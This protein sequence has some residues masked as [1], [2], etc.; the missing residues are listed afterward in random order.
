MIL[1][2]VKIIILFLLI[3]WH[4]KKV[5]TVRNWFM[6]WFYKCLQSLLNLVKC[7]NGHQCGIPTSWSY[8]NIHKL[9]ARSDG[10]PKWT[11]GRCPF[12]PDTQRWFAS[13]KLGIVYITIWISMEQD[14]SRREYKAA[15]IVTLP[16]L[17]KC[18]NSAKFSTNLFALDYFWIN[19]N[20]YEY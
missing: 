4:E 8:K 16:A 9:S 19:S 18:Q 5:I 12:F 15:K 7:F 2:L 14:L 1:I 10:L 20:Y 17:W 13:G 11:T 3:E 6:L